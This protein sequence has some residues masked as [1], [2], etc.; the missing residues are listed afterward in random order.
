MSI[1]CQRLTLPQWEDK[2]DEL[3]AQHSATA[4][5]LALAVVFLAL[6]RD[7]QASPTYGRYPGEEDEP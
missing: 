3:A 2:L 7:L 5:E 1:G 6:C 4:F